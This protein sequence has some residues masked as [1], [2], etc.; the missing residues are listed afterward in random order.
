M[1][2]GA[3]VDHFEKVNRE[4]IKLYPVWSKNW[5]RRELKGAIEEGRGEE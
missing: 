4:V 2:L 3:F 1:I 5:I